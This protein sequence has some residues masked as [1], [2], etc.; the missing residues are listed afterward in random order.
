ME[1][2][3][4]NRLSNIENLLIGT[5]QVLNFDEVATYTGLSKSYL[6]KLT[7]TGQIP[8]YKPRSKMCYFNKIEVDNWLLQNRVTPAN[9]LET[10]ATHYVSLKKDN[11][12]KDEYELGAESIVNGIYPPKK[13]KGGKAI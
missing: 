7:S 11:R 4:E 2:T 8:H 12:K 9:E 1:N 13:I 10:K 6:Y 5:K 3:I